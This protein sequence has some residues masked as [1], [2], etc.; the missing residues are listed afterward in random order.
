MGPKGLGGTPRPPTER[1]REKADGPAAGR[2]GGPSDPA[3]SAGRHDR[4]CDRG[5]KAGYAAALWLPD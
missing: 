1:Q 2:K 5:M 4:S 3:A